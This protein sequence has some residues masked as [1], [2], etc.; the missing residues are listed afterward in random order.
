MAERLGTPVKK[1]NVELKLR[2][3]F[4]KKNQRHNNRHILDDI[5]TNTSSTL[6]RKKLF[7]CR[8]Y[9]QVTLLSDMT[10]IK[11]TSVLSNGLIDTRSTNKR[12]TS[13]CPLQTKPNIHSWKL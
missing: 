8:L 1:H 5:L 9:L 10:D 11:E 12:Q 3:T 6:S 4:L 7:A 2:D 13:S